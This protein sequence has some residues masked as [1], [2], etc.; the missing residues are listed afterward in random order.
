MRGVGL[1]TYGLHNALGVREVKNRGEEA[2]TE[3]EEADVSDGD[4]I[5]Q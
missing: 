2:G 1:G 4:N 5:Y 3:E